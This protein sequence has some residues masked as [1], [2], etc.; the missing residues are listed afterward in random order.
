MKT[1]S[2]V[3]IYYT[4]GTY[5]EFGNTYTP[6]APYPNYPAPP[7]WTSPFTYS[8]PKHQTYGTINNVTCGAGYMEGTNLNG[9]TGK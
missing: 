3:V 6:T 7:A 9:G 4:D 1:I 2:R 8:V 5:Q